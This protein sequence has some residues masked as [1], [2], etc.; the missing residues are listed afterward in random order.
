MRSKEFRSLVTSLARAGEEQEPRCPHTTM[1]GGCAFQDRRYSDQVAAKAEALNRLF[2][3]T[4]QLAPCLPAQPLEVVASPDPY[5]YRTRMDY[6][7]T[8]GRFGL[9]ARGKFNYIVELETCHLIPPAAFAAAKAIWNSATELGLPD[10]N[11]RTHEGF[12]RYVVVRR[13]PTD[14][15]LLAVVT[16]EGAQYEPAMHA[17]AQVA[18]AQ[19]GVVGFHWL[20]NASRT[21]LSFGTPVRNWGNATL[22]MRAGATELAIGPNT[23]FQN[24]VHL[25]ERLLDDV[26]DAVIAASVPGQALPTVGDLYGGVG[27][28]ALH[29]APHAATV[30]CVEAVEESA[31]LAARNAEAH[32]VTNVQAFAQE[33]LPFLQ[34]SAASQLDLVVADPPRTG[35]GPEVCAELLRLAPARIVYVSCNPLTQIEDLQLLTRRYRVEQLQGYDMFPHTPHVETMAILDLSA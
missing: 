26:R 32:G 18:L 9:R 19:P 29:L 34:S 3:S 24:N 6:V 28:L 20:L 30:M 15:L 8:K 27:T 2:A 16:A 22:L 11:L 35:L 23:F 1:C 7:A 25:L 5:A 14:A 17:L 12:L 4:E 13:S 31:V 33:V 10:Y 21:D